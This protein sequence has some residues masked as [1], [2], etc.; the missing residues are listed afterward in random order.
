MSE[1]IQI[2]ASTYAEGVKKLNEIRRKNPER[3]HFVEVNV[4]GLTF[5]FKFYNTYLQIGRLKDGVNHSCP[6]G[7]N[8]TQFKS[9]LLKVFEN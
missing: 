5:Q 2:N 3:W 6:M 4:N 7:M 8:V 9:E 1:T